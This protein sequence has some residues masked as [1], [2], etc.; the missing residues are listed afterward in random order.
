MCSHTG[1]TGIWREESIYVQGLTKPP[2]IAM[3]IV[4]I[5]NLPNL[6]EIF[7]DIYEYINIFS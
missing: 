6:M 1:M 3:A 4:L 2:F 5:S 7:Y